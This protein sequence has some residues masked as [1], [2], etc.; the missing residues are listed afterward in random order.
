M[1]LD[2]ASGQYLDSHLAQWFKACSRD[3]TQ[4][5]PYPGDA[6]TDA[7]ATY[8]DWGGPA[9][10]ASVGSLSGCVG[11]Y[12]GIFDMTGNVEEWIDACDSSDPKSY[13]EIMGGS[14]S[15]DVAECRTATYGTRDER[16]LGRGFRC[17]ARIP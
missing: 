13:C 14:V 12:P 3:G 16:L 9:G 1:L 17:C 5:F 15:S 4:T 6:A 2:T 8:G 10:T 11:G 7:C